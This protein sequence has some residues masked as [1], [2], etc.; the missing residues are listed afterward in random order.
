MC[1]ANEIRRLKR[2][3]AAASAVRDGLERYVE[4]GSERN[5]VLP[6]LLDALDA[7]R[8]A[9]KELDNA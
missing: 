5:Y 9:Y 6:A 3:E 2:I 1:D 4:R 8:A 7:A